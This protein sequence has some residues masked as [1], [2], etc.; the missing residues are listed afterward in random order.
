MLGFNDDKKMI[1]YMSFEDE[2][3]DYIEDLDRFIN[4]YFNYD[5]R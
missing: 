5:F 1:V 4:E 2:D 3:L